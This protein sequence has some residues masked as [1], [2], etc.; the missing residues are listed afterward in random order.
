MEIIMEKGWI[1]ESSAPD[2]KYDRK[3]AVSNYE[4]INEVVNLPC[5]VNSAILQSPSR[6]IIGVWKLKSLK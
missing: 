1:S 4:G 2:G 3:I 6:T 5:M